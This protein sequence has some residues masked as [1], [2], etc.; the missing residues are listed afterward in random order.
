MATSTATHESYLIIGG[1]MPLGMTIV[2]QLLRRGETRVSIF[3]AQPL[4]AEQAARLGDSVRVYVGNILTPEAISDAVQ[5]CGA[6]CIIHTSVVATPTAISAL[7]PT[8]PAQPSVSRADEA[9]EYKAVVEVINKA[10]TDG[11]RNV[12]AAALDSGTVTQLVYFGSADSVFDGRDRPMLREVDAQYPPKSWFSELDARS[13]GERMVLSFNGVNALRTA[14]IRPANLF[15]PGYGTLR[16]LRAVQAR[17][18]LLAWQVGENTN[19][20]DKTSYVNAAHAALLA[21]DRLA[22]AHPQHFATAGRAFFIHDGE[23]RPVWDYMRTLWAATG[24]ARPEKPQV[25][26]K[27][28][29]LFFAGVKDMVGNLRGDKSEVWKKTQFLC[30]NRTYDLSLAR[31]VLGYAPIVSHDEGIRQ[32]AEW[33]LERQ[34][35][36]CKG[37]RAITEPVGGNAPPPYDRDEAMLLSEKSPFF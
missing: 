15:G 14:V 28:T 33:W 25:I 9:K 29:V 21:A 18:A 22:P 12:L 17:P 37:Q 11:M 20:V 7:Y 19:L 35:K 5:S 16:A 4:V 34:L 1:G 23:S 24:G 13:H 32:T 27:G 2:H 10:N 36:M 31:E 3:E 26:G 30:A 8:G 6:T